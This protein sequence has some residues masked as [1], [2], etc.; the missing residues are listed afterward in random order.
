[1]EWV[2]KGLTSTF[3]F[4]PLLDSLKRK[5]R[6]EIAAKASYGPHLFSWVW[7]LAEAGAHIP[8]R[9]RFEDTSAPHRSYRY[10][11]GVRPFVR[12]GLFASPP[13]S[14]IK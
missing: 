13:K 5:S 7:I 6:T 12:I 2:K 9:N 4:K 3:I 1:M 11:A 8:V 10:N 14:L